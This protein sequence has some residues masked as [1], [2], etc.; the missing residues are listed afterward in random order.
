M[1]RQPFSFPSMAALCAAVFLSLVAPTVSADDDS[2]PDAALNGTADSESAAARDARDPWEGFNRKVFV[3]NDSIDSAV[4]KPVSKTFRTYVPKPIR[5]GAGNFF[6]N[7]QDV[8]N[9]LNHILQLDAPDAFVTSGRLII[10][11]TLGV[12]GLFDVAT[13]VGLNRRETDTG[14][15]LA[16]W[17]VGSG[18]YLM[19][20]FFGPSTVRDGVGQGIDF[21]MIYP[22]SE[23]EDP[24]VRWSLYGLEFIGRRANLLDAEELISG[25]RY[26]F[27]R[28]VYLQNRRFEVTGELPEDDF[29][30]DDFGDDDFEDGDW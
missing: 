13:K 12:A 8:P 22:V 7:L 2:G 19:M 27:L 28:E 26:V 30:D 24:A 1:A 9:L 23:V 20:P 11:T 18:P 25:D 6:D 16:H 3:F 5:T 4:V 17:G 21:F 29:G 15:T 14:L 10:N